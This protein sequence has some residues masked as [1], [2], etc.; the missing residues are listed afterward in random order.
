MGQPNGYN[1]FGR[2]RCPVSGKLMHRCRA[3]A[4]IHKKKLAAHAGYKLGELQ[5]YECQHCKHWHVGHTL[6]PHAK[7][8]RSKYARNDDRRPDADG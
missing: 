3:Q 4:K 1:I 7:A 2:D 6:P 5:V 8:Y